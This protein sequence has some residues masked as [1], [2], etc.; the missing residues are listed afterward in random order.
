[1]T[2]EVTSHGA[3]LVIS[4]G[5][6]LHPSWL[7]LVCCIHTKKR[8]YISGNVRCGLQLQAYTKTGSPRDF[9]DLNF[10][11]TAVFF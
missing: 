5:A 9:H 3:Q 11:R 8:G 2:R 4:V 7:K 6:N 1:M 10:G